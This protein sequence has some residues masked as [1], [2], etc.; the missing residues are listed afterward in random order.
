MQNLVLVL[1][2]Q[3]VTPELA[4]KTRSQGSALLKPLGV[5]IPEAC[6]YRQLLEVYPIKDKC[7]EVLSI[8]KYPSF[9]SLSSVFSGVPDTSCQVIR[10]RSWLVSS[11]LAWLRLQVKKKAPGRKTRA[12]IAFAVASVMRPAWDA[13]I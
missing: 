9:A 11:S 10:V 7:E 12:L 6:F 4:L 3:I 2:N 1:L 8:P 5:A 13:H